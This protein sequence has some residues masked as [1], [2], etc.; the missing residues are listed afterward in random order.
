MKSNFSEVAM[1]MQLSKI[2]IIETIYPG[3]YLH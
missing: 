1:V 3:E 2:H